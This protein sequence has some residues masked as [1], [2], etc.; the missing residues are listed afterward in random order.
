VGV[1]LAV[2]ASCAAFM[3]HTCARD[4]AIDAEGKR[5]LAL[6]RAGDVEAAHAR[7]SSAR[8]AHLSVEEL[9]A[10][11][12]HPAFR[13]HREATLHGLDTNGDGACTPGDLDVAGA[14]WAL[15]L[16]YV[17]EQG[18]WRVHSFAIQ[19]PASVQ[20]GTLLPECGYWEGTT[21]GYRGP[22][23]ERTTTPTE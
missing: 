21:Q 16:F 14:E 20:L 5:F 6:L 13:A 2:V 10:L 17:E 8:R 23:I 19:P 9:D 18:G 7:L 1:L 12:D 15:E 4:E 3:T 11:T 22:P